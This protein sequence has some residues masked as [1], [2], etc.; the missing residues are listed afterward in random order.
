MLNPGES[1]VVVHNRAAFISRYGT[2]IRV[3][4]EYSGSLDNAGD[5]LTLLGPLGEPILDFSYDPSW[6]P[7]TDGGG[8]SLVAVDPTAP[9]ERLG[10]G[11]ELAALELAGRFSRQHRSAPAAR[12]AQRHLAFRQ[13]A[14]AGLARQFRQL[15]LI[16]GRLSRGAG[17]MD[18]GDRFAGSSGWPVGG[19]VIV[20]DRAS[21]YRLQGQPVSFH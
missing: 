2:G 1:I 9:A 13:R 14:Q 19:D 5:D 4:G 6:Y 7:I 20:T 8:F 3:A 10:S 17:R 21:F 11:A 12:G 16:F 15:Q 18:A